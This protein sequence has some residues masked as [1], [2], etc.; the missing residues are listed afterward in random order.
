MTD[1]MTMA[2]ESLDPASASDEARSGVRRDPAIRRIALQGDIPLLDWQ[3]KPVDCLR[4]EYR[5]LREAGRC[6]LGHACVQDRY[7]RRID[8][9]F[10]WNPA[11]SNE[12]LAHPYF[13]RRAVA[14]KRADVFRLPALIADEDETVRLT[15][16]LRLPQRQLLKLVQ[17]PHREVRIRVAQ[18]LDADHL[19]QMLRD[20]DYHVRKLVARRLTVAL[21]PLLAADPDVE[22][23]QEVAQRLEMPALLRMVEDPALEVRRVVAQRLPVGLLDRL[24][25]DP[26]WLVRWEVAQRA[27]PAVLRQMEH[28]PDEEVSAVARDRLGRPAR[29]ATGG[30][31]G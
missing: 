5:H 13:E 16:A 29:P 9:F 6:E 31:H 18:R 10:H 3:G 28:D 14:A 15:I 27:E 8:R 26:E 19:P 4:C 30:S 21:L 17:D 2:D 7:A 1:S 11:L 23:R 24:V 25:Q 20:E 12:S 22:V